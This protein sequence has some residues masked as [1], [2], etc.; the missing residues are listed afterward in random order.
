[1]GD[2]ID[3]LDESEGVEAGVGDCYD[4][5]IAHNCGSECEKTMECSVCERTFSVFNMKETEDSRDM[6]LE[7]F[8]VFAI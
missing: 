2:V 3:F 7:C 1:M 6:C 4:C 8:D 5:T